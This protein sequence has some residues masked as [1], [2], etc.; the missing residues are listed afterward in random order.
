[1]LQPADLLAAQKVSLGSDAT[2][3]NSV[4]RQLQRL[5]LEGGNGGV[6]DAATMLAKMQELSTKSTGAEDLKLFNRLINFYTTAGAGKLSDVTYPYIYQDAD[7]KTVKDDISVDKIVGFKDPDKI[8]GDRD[9][10]IFVSRS[11][12][13]TPMARD[14]QKVEL[15]LNFLPTTVIS[16][17]V[18]YLEL[19]FE[20]DRGI[21][22]GDD[23]A[24]TLTTAG[25]LKFLLGG[26][27]LQADT[28]NAAM[29]GA[30]TT[31][32]EDKDSQRMK[33]TAGMELFT[34][35][36]TLINMDPVTAK[37][38]KR[39]V[40]VIDPTRPFA[41][42]ENVTI[43]VAPTVGIMSYKKA[44]AV[45]KLH[46]RSRLAELADLIQPTTYTRTTVWLTYGWRHPYEPASDTKSTQTYADFINNNM[47]IREA[48]GVMNA[49][50]AFDQV[51]QVT[52]TLELF[53]K[54]VSEMRDIKVTDDPEEGFKQISQKIED[55][56]RQIGELRRAYNLNPPTGLN[57]E[58]RGFMVLDTAEQGGFPNLKPNEVLDAITALETA[59][60]N[61]GKIGAG[62][63]DPLIAK[64]K[65]LYA[66]AGGAN[67]DVFD[68]QQQYKN[69]ASSYV[70]RKFEELSRGPDPFLPFRVKDDKRKA[71]AGPDD[72]HPLLKEMETYLK[73][74]PLSDDLKKDGLKKGYCSFGKLFSVFMGPAL[75]T[76]KSVDEF[77][78]LFYTLNDKCGPASAISIAE[79]PIDLPVFLRQY[80]EVIESR[81]TTTM[82]IEQF[83]K[84]AIDA[85]LQDPRAIGY[86]FKSAQV[87][88][89]WDPKGRDP[90]FKDNAT[91]SQYDQLIW[92]VNGQRGA[93]QMPQIEVYI[94]TTHA[95]A[96][97]SDATKDVPTDLLR[98]YEGS[99]SKP[100]SAGFSKIKKIVRVHIYDKTVN[101][102]RAAG[103]LLR[104][105]TPLGSA[106]SIYE[107]DAN[108]WV[109]AYHGDDEKTVTTAGPLKTKIA[110]KTA[111]A[112]DSND[113]PIH[114]KLIEVT[115][116]SSNQSIK[117]L[118]SKMVPSLVYG[119]N[120]SGIID[121]SV[122]TKHDANLTAAQLLGLNS[123]KK[124]Q[125]T[126]QGGGM[127]GL[128]L[129][130]IPAALTLRTIGC[131]L[132]NYSQL[133][134]IDFN[135]GTTLDNIYGI[136]GLTHTLAP[137]KFESSLT[138]AFYDAYGK[139]E[140]APQLVDKIKSH[141]LVLDK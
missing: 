5:M 40:D 80:K 27:K 131:P 118:V 37:Q 68:Y 115:E 135:T 18:P 132:L 35:P 97:S 53:T 124:V 7:G 17:C 111:T 123:G 14:A 20:F 99:P 110:S 121:A 130:V 26:D 10:S 128:P 9:L 87:F 13:I 137:G 78:L 23:K 15:F 3:R 117:H 129:K 24:L 126:P 1:M 139:Y 50:F 29:F 8:R 106:S 65:Q 100:G 61:S 103:A 31:V 32:G 28:P 134:F 44:T 30:R 56:A 109:K 48:Y 6:Y 60:R 57:K 52:I 76:V 86:G 98:Y 69:I 141:P 4:L 119:M 112:S 133:F 11:P 70:A 136:S 19:E 96:S 45:I 113:S 2:N 12:F 114:V 33:S 63:S 62:T 79:F 127:G 22:K 85:Q 72:S 46:D 94:E 92:S 140:G 67:K 25:M 49:G 54:S 36:Q 73:S 47:L 101:P 75:F 88:K 107:V 90:A 16:R 104:A 38:G 91:A 74:D 77:Q 125:A 71:E 138:M 84:L 41:S 82:T 21:S 93:F 108:S 102:Y 89:P 59:L 122:Q 81:G 58:I 116:V 66:S 95:K 34:A 43:N 83:V 64:L 120:A 51:G 39:Y 105:D 55:L 42:L